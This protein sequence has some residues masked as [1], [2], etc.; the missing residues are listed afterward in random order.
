[1]GIFIHWTYGLEKLISKHKQL[2]LHSAT[3]E[4]PNPTPAKENA[5]LYL[6]VF[7]QSMCTVLLD[8]PIHL[9]SV[10]SITVPSSLPPKTHSYFWYCVEERHPYK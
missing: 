5:I 3:E 1:M 6:L 9:F 8:I 7:L 4:R 2:Y 10:L